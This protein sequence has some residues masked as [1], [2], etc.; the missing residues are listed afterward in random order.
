MV[1]ALSLV[2]E[3]ASEKLFSK[4]KKKERKEGKVM[5]SASKMEKTL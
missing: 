2:F 1:M 4:L 3:I 5:K